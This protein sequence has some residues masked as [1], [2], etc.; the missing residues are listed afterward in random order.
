MYISATYS[1]L[2][3]KALLGTNHMISVDATRLLYLKSQKIPT[4][5]KFKFLRITSNIPL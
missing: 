3:V 5:R 4:E 1:I 2:L